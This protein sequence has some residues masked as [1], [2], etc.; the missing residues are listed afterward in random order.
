[1]RGLVSL[2]IMCLTGA[3]A[4][5]WTDV[6]I[7]KSACS[8]GNNCATC[9]ENSAPRT[10]TV[11]FIET[12]HG[13]VARLD[14]Q[15]CMGCHQQDSCTNCHLETPPVWHT[16]AFRHPARG[17]R[18]RDEHALVATGHRDKCSECHVQRFQTQCGS[19]HRPDEEDLKLRFQ[20]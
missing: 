19:C 13:P 1:M 20:D 2:T 12:G 8:E 10:H 14:R 5:D 15:Q 18:E 6:P 4:F 11:D 3:F 7:G 17:W 9:H 16:E